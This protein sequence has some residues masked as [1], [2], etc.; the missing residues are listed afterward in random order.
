MII[1]IIVL[2]LITHVLVIPPEVLRVVGT[3]LGILNTHIPLPMG[4]GIILHLP[5]VIT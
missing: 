4:L 2:V 5:L 3:I 1:E